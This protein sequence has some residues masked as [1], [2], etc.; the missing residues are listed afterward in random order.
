MPLSLPIFNPGLSELNEELLRVKKNIKKEYHIKE[1]NREV[2]IEE[3]I[4]SHTHT[5]WNNYEYR[6]K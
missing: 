1:S 4:V 2:I 5:E 6:K 3:I